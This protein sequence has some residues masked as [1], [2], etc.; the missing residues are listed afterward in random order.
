MTLTLSMTTYFSL[1]PD[2]VLETHLF[3]HMD[4]WAAVKYCLAQGDLKAAAHA[5]LSLY[6]Q[7]RCF[8]ENISAFDKLVFKAG[9]TLDG[10]CRSATPAYAI[11]CNVVELYC[12]LARRPSYYCISLSN[13]VWPPLPACAIFYCNGHDI[14]KLPP[15][16][17]VV[18]LNC[19]NNKLKELSELPKCEKLYCGNNQ[20]CALPRLDSCTVLHCGSN[21]SFNHGTT[22]GIA[23]LP[24]LPLCTIL[25]CSHN[26]LTV[27]PSLDACT[28]L[29]CTSNQLIELPKLDACV[30]L[31]CSGNRLTT[32]PSMPVC[33]DIV[34]INNR[35]IV[36]VRNTI[37]KGC[38]IR[39]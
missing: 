21:W 13:I 4:A 11:I 3:K 28:K 29:N 10:L 24:A 23:A 18:I 2:H 20:L 37:N 30:E 35:N 25:D 36:I 26:L 9:A 32:L 16:P 33:K 12:G 1:L 5:D 27:L 15:L 17:N 34:C 8:F 14:T 6:G 39:C 19:S 38:K 7:Y 22:Y 31:E